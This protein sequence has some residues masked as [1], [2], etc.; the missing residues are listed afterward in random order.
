MESLGNS[1]PALVVKAGLE[2]EQEALLDACRKIR[3]HPM[4]GWR[5][6]RSVLHNLWEATTN[7]R[8]ALRGRNRS[9]REDT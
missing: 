7:F 2:P 4:R 1:L 9:V 8:A 3:P 5:A 6:D